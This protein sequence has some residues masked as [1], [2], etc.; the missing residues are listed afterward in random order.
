MNKQVKA[1][2]LKGALQETFKQNY[3]HAVLLSLAV[4]AGAIINVW[5]S[6]V[7]RRLVDGPLLSGQGNLWLLSFVYLGAMLLIGLVDLAREYGATVFGQSTLLAIRVRML[8]RL[9]FLPMSYYLNVP[10]GE[11]LSRFTADIDAVNTLFSAGLVSAAA[12]LLKIAGFVIALFALSKPLGLIALGALPVVYVVADYFRKNIYQKQL[13][14]RKRVSDINTSLQEI[15]S[16][17][18]V[19]K[20]F[21]RE[22]FFA[23][24]FEP[25]LENHR[26]AMNANS[27]YEA[28][29]PCITQTLRAAV[30]ALAIFIGASNNTT[31]LALGLSL[32]TL[33]AAADLFIRLFEPIEAISSEIQTIQQAR[34]GLNRINGFFEQETEKGERPEGPT[35]WDENDVSVKIEDVFFAYKN[36]EDVLRGTTIILPAGAKAAIAGRTGSGKTTLMNLIAGLYPL[37]AGQI[38]IG[39]VD[40]YLL[41]PSSRRRL[42]GIVP[43]TVHLFNGTV[44]D[45]ITLRDRSITREQA[46]RALATVE[47]LETIKQFPQQLDT[48]IG[49]GASTLSFGQTQL[50]SLARAIVTDPPLLL[51]D[52]LT[53]G[54]DAVTEKHV[55]A[56]IRKMSTK[57]TIITISHRLSGIIDADV[58][59]IMERG[60]VMESGSPDKL[61]QKEGWYSIYKRLEERG[62]RIS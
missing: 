25:T 6:L 61:A 18:K 3:M 44:Y 53:S 26:L 33:A 16:G 59:H 28:W 42:I 27:F 54:L 31:S 36:S 20:S 9:R 34:A 52:E 1:T 17:M 24:R 60:R 2:Y 8:D 5:P 51:L 15:Y 14:V 30:I 32:G 43:Q 45:N 11:T 29:F 4:I 57:R 58:V 38:T 13:L 10:T 21:G 23:E 50:L 49:E 39:G 62:W 7:L 22:Q 41:T 48:V 56:A 37:R 55:L 47:L 19:I 40:P 12:D 35:V 46:E